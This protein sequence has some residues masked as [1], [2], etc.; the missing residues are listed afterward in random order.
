MS[1]HVPVVG[2]S[3]VLKVMVLTKMAGSGS[4]NQIYETAD[5]DPYQI[6]TDPHTA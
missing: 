1:L 3:T 4:V 5:P 6:V 2:I